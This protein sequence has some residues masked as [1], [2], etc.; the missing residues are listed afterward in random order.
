MSASVDTP[1]V[2]AWVIH[3][4]G[5]S[6]RRSTTGA[7]SLWIRAR[8]LFLLKS[9]SKVS[10]GAGRD[11]GSA[12]AERAVGSSVLATDEF[13]ADQRRDEIDGHLSF[14]LGLA[15]ARVGHAGE[16]QLAQRRVEFDECAASTTFAGRRIVAAQRDSCRV[17]SLLVDEIAYSVSCRI[18]GSTCRRVSGAAGRRSR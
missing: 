4:T 8:F 6:N 13:V 17:S 11:R 16:E 5:T 12:P 2:D 3:A 10:M 15:Q 7:R 18:S 1:L 14:R 9:R